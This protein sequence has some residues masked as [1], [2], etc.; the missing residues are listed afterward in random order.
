M[1]Q[2]IIIG[3]K[4]NKKNVLYNYLVFSI[5]ALFWG[6]LGIFGMIGSL[7][8][9]EIKVRFIITLIF[10]IIILLIQ[11]P[12]I[13]ATQRIEVSNSK[14]DYFYTKGYFNQ[15]KEVFRILTNRPEATEISINIDNLDKIRLSYRKTMSGYG[16][17]GYALVIDFLMN[18]TTLITLSPE[19]MFNFDGVLYKDAIEMITNHNVELIDIFS[20]KDYLYGDLKPFQEYIKKLESVKSYE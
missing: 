18:D 15:F 11:T 17:I 7:F 16:L 4:L 1:K 12:M 6:C 13:G 10:V 19:N 20:L 3:K 2:K 8:S 5:H 14:I 9:L